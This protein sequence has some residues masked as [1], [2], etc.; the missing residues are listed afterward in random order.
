MMDIL[1]KFWESYGVSYLVLFILVVLIIPTLMETIKKKGGLMDKLPACV[2]W[3]LS[4]VFT[5]IA[6]LYVDNAPGLGLVVHSWYGMPLHLLICWWIQKDSNMIIIK[7]VWK[8]L[9]ARS[10][11]KLQAD[12]DGD[13]TIG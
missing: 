7:R 8:A 12:L 10:E 9:V 3:F 4:M 6:V 5:V 1:I 2:Y 11:R 13:G